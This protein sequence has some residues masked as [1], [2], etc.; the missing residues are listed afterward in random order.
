MKLLEKDET[1][2]SITAFPRYLSAGCLNYPLSPWTLFGSISSSVRHYHPYFSLYRKYTAR[3]F[4]RLGCPDFTIPTQKATPGEGGVSRSLFFP[5]AAISSHPRFKTLTR[6]IRERRGEKVAINI[7]SKIITYFIFEKSF[8]LFSNPLELSVCCKQDKCWGLVICSSKP[9]KLCQFLS[10][11]KMESS[12]HT[13]YV[14]A[15]C[16]A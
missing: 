11:P 2:L 10:L 14:N 4:F 15:P 3:R 12:Y 6:N 7:P 1:P 9:I 8:L 5:D 13:R 16:K